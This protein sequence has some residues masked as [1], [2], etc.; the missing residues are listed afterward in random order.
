[1]M[2]WDA[3]RYDQQHGFVSRYGAGL[4]ALLEP[5]K[6]EK[7][8][9]LGCGTGDLAHEI[10]MSGAQVTGVD[11]SESM[12]EKARK[13]F[14]HMMFEC[15]DAVHLVGRDDYDAVFSNAVLHWIK[16]QDTVLKNVYN[17]LKPGGRFVAEMG[18][19]GNVQKV[20]GATLD[21]IQKHGY[22]IDE[23][24]DNWYFPSIGEYASKLEHQGFTLRFM[25]VYDRPTELNDA[26][27]GI[28][29]WLEMFGG[30]LFKDVKEEDKMNML[31]EIQANLKD[32]LVTEGRWYADYKRLR[33]FA[34]K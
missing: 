3:A 16:D 13:K 23:I 28:I 14:P 7:I 15:R 5:L 30:N 10:S 34:V 4:V 9:D 1:M 6:G 18:A 24:S 21:V 25:E 2:R 20:I 22:T 12:I 17:S 33:F 31:L 26:E 8:L 27:N 19:K 32:E 29:N 11:A